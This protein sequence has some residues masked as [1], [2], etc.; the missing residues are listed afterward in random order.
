MAQYLMYLGI[1][2]TVGCIT[3]GFISGNRMSKLT[4]QVTQAKAQWQRCNTERMRDIADVAFGV[5]ELET[6]IMK[7]LL[8]PG[9]QVHYNTKTGK[10][11]IIK[12]E[13]G[14]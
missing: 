1:G 13:K 6:S 4:S 11:T 9:E 8:A 12:P 7:N 5:N 2:F 14:K 10:F 3:T